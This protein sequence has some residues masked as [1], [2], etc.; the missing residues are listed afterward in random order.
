MMKTLHTVTLALLLAQISGFVSPRTVTLA[1]SSS[2]LYKDLERF[3]DGTIK[4]GPFE[5]MMDPKPTKIPPELKDEIYKAESNTEAARQRQGR[6][7][8]YISLAVVLVGCA[9]CN[10]FI[11]EFRST[12][13]EAA[14]KPMSLD[15]IGWGWVEMN[16]LFKFLLTSKIGGG[17]AM[18]GGA[19]S[20]MMVEA[21]VESQRE[22]AEKIWVELEKRRESKEKRS[23]KKKSR[24]GT[25]PLPSSKKKRSATQ[26]KRLAAL[27]EVVL[28]DAAPVEVEADVGETGGADIAQKD[29][30]LMGKMKEFYNKADSMA[31]SQ[32][33]L[34]NKELED[35]GVL[36]KITDESGL[37]VIGKEAAAKMKEEK[38]GEANKED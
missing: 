10:V 29:E 13:A 30:G 23:K 21:E 4:K 11:T 33:L 12:V 25:A 26:K 9:F 24:K 5:F 31:A 15:D 7:L 27:S 19:T 37:R 32:A 36:D 16:F 2:Q 8:Q 3:D 20:G 18:I 38:S 22:N 6:V 34:L 17:L 35:K 14:G 1:S 28:E